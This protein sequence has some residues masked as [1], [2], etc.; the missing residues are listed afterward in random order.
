MRARRSGP[1]LLWLAVL[2]LFMR[3]DG[4][5]AEALV[6]D[7]SSH[8]VAITAGFTGTDVVL[9]GAVDGPGD[10][11]VVVRG[12][13]GDV[14]VR[15]KRR[16]AGVWVN[17]DEVEFLGVPSFYALAS[18]VPLDERITG[19]V[20]TPNEIGLDRLRLVAVE[21]PPDF[22]LFRLAL[23]RLK[24][25]LGHFV[26]VVGK[27]SF[28]GERLFRANFHF[29]ANVP[30]GSYL[31]EVLLVRDGQIVSAQTTPLVVGKIG[32]GA[33]IYQFAHRQAPLYGLVAILGALIAGWLAHLAFRRR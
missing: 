23:L 15:R 1:T 18:S 24:R 19:N 4:A 5:A 13:A 33:E 16:I 7:L 30:T 29:P 26:P 9:F 10:V 32:I 22:A 2:A 25:G 11:I 8:L 20:L 28:L 21:E 6:A 17:R 31:V 14:T 27:V 3:A 12:P